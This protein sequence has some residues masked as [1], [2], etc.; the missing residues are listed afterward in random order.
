MLA[1]FLT[2]SGP[3]GHKI[4]RVVAEA[5]DASVPDLADA[6]TAAVLR[7]RWIAGTTSADDFEAAID[8][9]AALPFRRYPA[10]PLLG[11]AFDL[12]ATV[13]VYDALYVALAE[14]L[15][16]ALLTADARLAQAPGPRCEIRVLR[17]M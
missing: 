3:V 14:S 10:A 1:N 15:G 12:R 9:L 7:K 13:T 11:R 5:G 16:C 6:E 2:D 4:R 8:D 17:P